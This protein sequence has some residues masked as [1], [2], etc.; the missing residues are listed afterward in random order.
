MGL[1]NDRYLVV[2][3]ACMVCEAMKL[4]NMASVR[5]SVNRKEMKD[6]RPVISQTDI[7]ALI[8]NSQRTVS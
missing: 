8:Q 5:V 6:L 4:I 3:R 2:T 1:E 7:R